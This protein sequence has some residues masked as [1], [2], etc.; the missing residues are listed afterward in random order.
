MEQNTDLRITRPD[1]FGRLMAD[2]GSQDQF[3]GLSDVF[4]ISSPVGPNEKNTPDDVA[5]A[6]II[7][8]S[9]GEL[10]LGQTDGPT[11]FFGERLR[12]AIM[13]FQKRAGLQQTGRL[14]ASDTTMIAARKALDSETPGSVGDINIGR[15]RDS[16]EVAVTPSL[17]SK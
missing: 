4:E 17:I 6:E 14:A 9:L 10:D 13:A 8:D 7:M 12:Q 5:R 16:Q 1:P 11:G 3:R 15:G 2:D